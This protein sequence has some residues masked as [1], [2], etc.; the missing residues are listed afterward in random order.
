MTPILA[1]IDEDGRTI[2]LVIANASWE[3]D[4]PATVH[5]KGFARASAGGT[6]LTQSDRNAVGLVTGEEVTRPLPIEGEAGTLRFTVPGH[7]I[8]FIRA[9]A[10]PDHGQ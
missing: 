1:T 9:E 8:A 6:V 10:T 7:S 2:Y 3:D 4:W 5:L